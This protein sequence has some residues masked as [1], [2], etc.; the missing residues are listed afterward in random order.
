MMKRSFFLAAACGL[1]ASLAFTTPSQAGL[2]L[3]T[4]EVSYGTLFP[5]SAPPTVTSFT[6]TY[7]VPTG[8]SFNASG[9]SGGI[10]VTYVPGGPNGY[11]GVSVNVTHP[12]TDTVKITFA[13]PVSYFSGHFTFESTTAA[14]T[15]TGAPTGVSVHVFNE[16]VPEPP[17]MAL[18]GIGMTSFLAFRRFFKRAPLA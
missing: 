17:S 14:T 5:P 4:T 13:S 6:L 8:M 2:M 11:A 16:A 7:T 18:L 12:G 9:L 15:P 1:L 10:L 3:V